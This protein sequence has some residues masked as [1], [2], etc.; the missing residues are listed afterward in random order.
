VDAETC[1]QTLGNFQISIDLLR[2]LFSHPAP[3]VRV[4][5]RKLAVILC[6]ARVMRGSFLFS[7]ETETQ[8]NDVFCEFARHFYPQPTS[9]CPS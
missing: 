8:S 2:L 3:T 1:W 4:G 6:E 7:L 5:L 9:V